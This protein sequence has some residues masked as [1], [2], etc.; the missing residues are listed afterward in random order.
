MNVFEGSRRI[1]Y[2][3]GIIA[4][5]ITLFSAITHEPYVTI[6]Y[7]VISPKP[8]IIKM[9][10]ECPSDAGQVFFQSKSQSKRLVSVELC[11][12]TQEF[13]DGENKAQLIAYKVDG[14]GMVWGNTEYSDDVSIYKKR[15]EAQFVI[16]EQDNRWIEDKA[17]DLYW[18]KWKES[19]LGLVLGLAIYS[20]FVWAVGWIVRGFMGIP[21]GMD[22]KP[23]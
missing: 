5:I 20:A 4:V 6:T 2:L 3:A 16:P 18:G 9:S 22:K 7:G 17:S 13:G 12:L 11:L 19:I 8:L 21:Y 23:N 15:L 14:N 1:A 10:R